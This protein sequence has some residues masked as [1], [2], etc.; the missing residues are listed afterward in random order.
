[1]TAIKERLSSKTYQTAAVLTALTILEAN[2][3]FVTQFIPQEY[4][5]YLVL[6]WPLAML[7]LRELTNAALASFWPK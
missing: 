3:Q 2:V 6:V 1:M 5:V 7:T 4:R